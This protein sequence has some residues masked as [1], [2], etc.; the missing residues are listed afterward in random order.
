MQDFRDAWRALRATP[1]V[2][3]VAILSLAL[4]IGANTAIF[5]ILDSLLLKPLPVREPQRLVLVGLADR[6][7]D[8]SHTYAI[9]KE[10]R[11]R[12]LIDHPFTWGTDRVGV[13]RAG[14]A[15]FAEAIWATGNFFDILGVSAILGRTFNER[16]DRRGG[17]PDGPV[18][19][20]S[21][22]MWRT[23]FG[24]APDV[25][26]RTLAIERVPFTIVG[27]TPPDFFGLT[28]GFEFDVILPLE[29]EPLIGHAPPRLDTRN[30]P[31]LQI[32]GR[33]EPAQT[34]E[35][36]TNTLRIAQP[37]IRGAT[38]PDY[39]RAEDRDR[40]LSKPWTARAV[41]AGV[42]RLR[43]QYGP[44]LRTLLG[45]V[46]LVLLVACANV[47]TLLLARTAARRYELSVRL[48]LGASQLRLVRQLL[49][50]SLLLSTIGAAV[51]L[52][53]AQWGSRLL[54][55][56]LSNWYYTVSLD[57]SLD[58]RVLGVTAAVTVATAVLFGTWPAYQAVHVEPIEALKL[59][60]RGL[61]GGAR[62]GLSGWLVIAQVALSLM[63]VVG[64]G[65]FLRSFT[66]LAYRDL[67][68]D[69][70]RLL[71]AVIDAR[72]TSV[73]PAGLAALHER[74][75]EAAAAVAGVESAAI[76]MAT[77]LGNAGVRF[78]REITVPGSAAFGTH[79]ATVFTTP[80]SPGW[81]RTFGTRLI[82]G[83]DFNA[84]DRAGSA[85]VAI[86]NE[87]FARRY[88]D[89]ANPLGRTLVEV[90]EPAERQPMEI[91]GLIEDAAFTSVRDAI[92]PTMYLPLTQGVDEK[93]LARS[94]SITV[95]VRATP[96]QPPAR[97]TRS[98]A[99]AI[100]SVDGELSVS[101]Q[102][103]AEQLDYFYIRERLL[104]LVSGFF[105]ALALLLAALGLYGVTAFAVNRR[106]VE[107]G[108]R[109]ALGAS[110][111]TVARLVI[112]R[113][114]GLVAIG[115]AIGIVV[116]FWTVR[117]VGAL[118]YGLQP[119]DPLT[120]SAACAVLVVVAIAAASLPTWRASRIDPASVLREG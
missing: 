53:F 76:S 101:F 1:L 42:S 60:P 61:A 96:G 29:C 9:W 88:L 110:P 20:I 13:S 45:V 74:A 114:V 19:V 24:G 39:R 69:R 89:R 3:S 81:F 108:I 79:E 113:V 8:A 91:V 87:A 118:L 116:S 57:L 120:F 111:G 67:G 77:P 28:V 78:T 90:V 36:L 62:V 105:G 4:G 112:G 16:D 72:R 46:G 10:I 44:A 18:A 98:L 49:V 93:Q 73:P 70:D 115:V 94:P 12:H 63:L 102:T 92:E 82:A 51:G 2:S 117:L 27:V 54:V 64:A 59:Q 32:M 11:D 68:F 75:R 107:I 31:W 119:R 84:G 25:I 26:G 6:N 71:I 17:G 15:M 48:A 30:W 99:A 35:A 56:Q 43:G 40:Y 85:R 66:A 83:R 80:V 7:A 104:A 14:E 103:V 38:M 34:P 22:R 23:R 21:D 41:P 106:R 109:M 47:G 86:V 95:T 100:A 52:A 65:L 37:Q 5:S 33:L 58:G 97:L 50:E 55:A